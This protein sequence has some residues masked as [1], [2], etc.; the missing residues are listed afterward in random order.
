MTPTPIGPQ[1][2]REALTDYREAFPGKD[3]RGERL[4]RPHP[5]DGEEI[6]RSAGGGQKEAAGERAFHSGGGATRPK[7]HSMPIHPSTVNR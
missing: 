2:L 5:P 3:E 7:H 4:H 1:A 6:G